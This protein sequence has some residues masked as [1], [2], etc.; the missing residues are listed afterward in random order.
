MGLLYIDPNLDIF[1]NFGIDHFPPT[2]SQKFS[3]SLFTTNPQIINFVE[4]MINQSYNDRVTGTCK[5]KE[6]YR[7]LNWKQYFK[8]RPSAGKTVESDPECLDLAQF[9]EVASPL[10]ADKPRY[11][12]S[13]AA[14]RSDID[15]WTRQVIPIAIMGYK[16][17]GEKKLAK[18][19]GLHEKKADMHVGYSF[20]KGVSWSSLFR[21][22]DMLDPKYMWMCAMV[23]ENAPVHLY[24]DF[25]ASTSSTGTTG[26]KKLA[27]RVQ[28]NEEL[29]KQ[30]FMASFDTF[31]RNTFGRGVNWAGLHWETASDVTAGKFSLHAHLITEAFV[32]IKHMHRFMRAYES[33]INQESQ[34]GHLQY[35]QEGDAVLLDAGVYTPNRSFRLV[36]CRKLHKTALTPLPSTETEAQLSWQ[37]LVF[38]GMPSLAI[39]VDDSDE[40]AFLKYEPIV[41]DKKRKRKRTAA[42]AAVEPTT[43]REDTSEDATSDDVLSLLQRVFSTMRI[44]GPN[45][46]IET[47]RTIRYNL[48]DT[49]KRQRLDRIRFQGKFVIQ[50]AWCPNRT[51][52]AGSCSSTPEVPHIHENTPMSF[53]VTANGITITDFRCGMDK[54]QTFSPNLVRANVTD[55]QW[56]ALF[57]PSAPIMPPAI[58]SESNITIIDSLDDME[59]DEIQGSAE[60][61][62]DTIDLQPCLAS[63]QRIVDEFERSKSGDLADLLMQMQV[64]CQQQNARGILACEKAAM[65]M[66]AA[67]ELEIVN[68][69]NRYWARF[70]RL[71][72]P[73]MV[74]EL[75]KRVDGTIRWEP[76]FTSLK[77]IKEMYSSF[78][79]QISGFLAPLRS[80]VYASKKKKPR[81]RASTNVACLWLDHPASRQLNNIIFNPQLPPTPLRLHAQSTD[82]TTIPDY[83]LWRGFA[84]TREMADAYANSLAERTGLSPS[85]AA[86]AEA[87]P[88]VDHIRTIWCRGKDTSFK[89]CFSWMANMLQ[90]CKKNGTAL[91]VKGPQGSG[92]GIVVQKLGEIVGRAGD[93]FFHAHNIDDV[94]GTYTHNLRAALLVFLDEVTYGGN[95]EQAQRLKKLVTEAT[96]SINGKY[97]PSYTVDSFLNAIIASNDAFVVLCEIRQRRFFTLEIDSERC[98]KQTK[99]L[100]EYY[101][102]ILAVPA[103]AFAYLLY[104]YDLTNFNPR[105]IHAT[106]FERDQKMRSFDPMMAWWHDCL[107]EQQIDGVEG[108]DVVPDEDNAAV[109][110]AGFGAVI[111]KDSVYNS[112]TNFCIRNRRGNTY[113]VTPKNEFWRLL[114]LWT[115]TTERVELGVRLTHPEMKRQVLDPNGLRTWAR[116]VEMPSLIDCRQAWKESVVFDDDWE[117][118]N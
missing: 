118:P 7:G 90:N 79:V 45:V 107:Q 83:N 88:L 106:E 62:T 95:K 42:A 71:E 28:G 1:T 66:D 96:H 59:T 47:C 73:W 37:E 18:S 109:Q 94:L 91:V 89:Y 48:T 30:E 77:S 102:K 38:R 17:R 103:A 114:D 87:K 35:L 82:T 116:V 14:L 56:C 92:K 74:Q 9:R 69:L 97:L 43:Q 6:V 5:F 27:E 68:Y 64:A 34:N 105:E 86:A 99:E 23:M 76:S 54:K 67:V 49:N 16:N 25:D 11:H 26:E 60:Q 61:L 21:A 36:G 113:H 70:L 78:N 39:D 108:T 50:S 117:F 44:L 81:T 110:L 101:D 4:K 112:F 46:Q 29:V 8:F 40:N 51:Q 10:A 13:L 63:I 20:M 98:G 41:K 58:D 32:D 84:I 80:V 24:F 55:A 3:W 65:E 31:F 100:K 2:S 72:K 93:H 111:V 15:A 22:Y 53:C 12:K 115:Q 75:G 33:Y 52:Y 104:H 57:T 85:E 19:K